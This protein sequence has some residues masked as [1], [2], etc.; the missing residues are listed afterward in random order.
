M[1]MPCFLRPCPG[2]A[3][4]AVPLPTFHPAL[5][6][7][8][9]DPFPSPSLFALNVF[10]WSTTRYLDGA[11]DDTARYWHWSL[12]LDP[13]GCLLLHASPA[14][15]TSTASIQG[16]SGSAQLVRPLTSSQHALHRCRG[17][18]QTADQ[19]Y[20]ALLVLIGQEVPRRPSPGPFPG[21]PEASS[22]RSV[23]PG[24]DALGESRTPPERATAS[25][26]DEPSVTPR[27]RSPS[28]YR[29]YVS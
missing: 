16:N 24:H 1:K 27:L 26:T 29:L 25:T 28:A 20:D 11:K 14:T 12:V 21:P 4:P 3:P 9:L 18:F 6:T 17:P 8:C 5:P 15:T 22:W 7:L 23:A 2:Q 13:L 10:G 19:S